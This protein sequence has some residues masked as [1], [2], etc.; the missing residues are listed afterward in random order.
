MKSAAAPELYCAGLLFD[1]KKAAAAQLFWGKVE[2]GVCIE[3]ESE[4][5]LFSSFLYNTRRPSSSLCWDFW[6]C[7]YVSSPFWSLLWIRSAQVGFRHVSRATPAALSYYST[8][9]LSPFNKRHLGSI[10]QFTGGLLLI[11]IAFALTLLSAHHLFGV[12][13]LMVMWALFR[14]WHS[15]GYRKVSNTN[16]GFYLFFSNQRYAKC[17]YLRAVTKKIGQKWSKLAKMFHFWPLIGS[18]CGY[19]SRAASIEFYNWWKN[20]RL[21]FEG[22]FYSRAVC[23]RD[24]T[25]NYSHLENWHTACRIVK[26]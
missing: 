20:V 21:L 13:C 8:N 23:I 12:E 2:C 24:F 11:L 18:S 6:M 22:G 10:L 9:S 25:V 3:G 16:R 4:V 17:F 15:S 26:T 19:Y 5:I 1:L 7:I 14:F